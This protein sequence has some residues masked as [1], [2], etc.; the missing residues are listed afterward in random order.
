MLK[1]SARSFCYD[2]GMESASHDVTWIFN[3]IVI[4]VFVA[5]FYFLYKLVSKIDDKRKSG[6]QKAG[7]ENNLEYWS[8][9]A[10]QKFPESSLL[11]F[12]K[13]YVSHG[14]ASDDS[15]DI[16]EAHFTKGNGQNDVTIAFLFI[17]VPL[18]RDT[19]VQLLI[20]S[21]KNNALRRSLL[22]TT[23]IK[24][25][26]EKVILE[27]NFPD[28]YEVFQI[29]GTQIQTLQF[30]NPLAM[31]QLVEEFKSYDFEIINDTAYM[32]TLL[33]N[34]L[35]NASNVK[36][37]LNEARKFQVFIDEHMPNIGIGTAI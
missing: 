37:F 26:L 36:Q 21:Q 31:Q 30:L 29:P 28:S 17:A 3:L 23:G 13:A 32:Y 35:L 7:R 19:G 18:S 15:L 16:G 34:D 4:S 12:T 2:D 10:A 20:D 14:L 22:D 33:S 6:I 8:G 27:G 11:G 9:P 25:G 5:F 1:N 24:G